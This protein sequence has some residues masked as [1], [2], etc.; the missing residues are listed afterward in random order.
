MCGVAKDATLVSVQ[1]NP[2]K[3]GGMMEALELILED[4]LTKNRAADSVVVAAQA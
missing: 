4:I 2:N 3:P 1:S